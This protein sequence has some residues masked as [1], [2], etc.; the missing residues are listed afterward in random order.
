MYETIAL[1]QGPV[2]PPPAEFRLSR[3]TADVAN[4]QLTVPAGT[5]FDPGGPEIT[6]EVHTRCRERRLRSAQQ[7]LDYHFVLVVTDAGRAQL[8]AA[9]RS[10][11]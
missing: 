3:G 6:D 1:D 4:Q 8:P 11:V 7:H 10:T 9:A 5:P 2:P